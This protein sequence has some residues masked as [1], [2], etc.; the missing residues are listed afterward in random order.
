MN[1]WRRDRASC[2]PG[3]RGKHGRPHFRG[4]GSHLN[5]R[6]RR[7][8]I[9]R[10][11][12][13]AAKNRSGLGRPAAS[14]AHNRS[15]GGLRRGHCDD[16]S[17]RERRG[18][19]ARWKRPSN[20]ICGEAESCPAGHTKPNFSSIFVIAD[21]ATAPSRESPSRL[22]SEALSALFAEGEVLRIV[23]AARRANHVGLM[24]HHPTPL[25]KLQHRFTAN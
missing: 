23:A 11:P 24:G 17:R 22:W 15:S 7:G 6:N 4:G 1:R 16:G 12:A 19:C 21:V 3:G 25:V 13:I 5:G 8:R 14:V 20:R 9:H 2:R 10:R 18:W